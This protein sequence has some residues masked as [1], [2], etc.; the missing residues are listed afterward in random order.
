MRA[1]QGHPGEVRV[2]P[3]LQGHVEIPYGW[4][5]C[6]YHVGVASLGCR[7]IADA[8]LVAGGTSGNRGRQTCCFTGVDPL[9]EPRVDPRHT[10]DQPRLVLFTFYWRRHQDAGYWF[11]LKIAQ[12]KGLI[13]WQNNFPCHHSQRLDASRVLGKSGE[14][15]PRTIR[16]EVPA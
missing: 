5:D 8:G 1:F 15:R 16:P 9:H 3:K 10:T 14:K 12:E 13:L 6:I 4:T 11:D 2:D 7:S